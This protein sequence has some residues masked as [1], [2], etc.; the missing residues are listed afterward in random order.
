MFANSNTVCVLSFL[1]LFLDAAKA[2]G[3]TA[4]EI[5]LLMILIIIG[6]SCG[7][8]ICIGRCLAN[9]C[10]GQPTVTVINKGSPI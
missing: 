2:D 6:V 1:M 3:S 5:S 4:A 10:C 7:I 8:C 9:C